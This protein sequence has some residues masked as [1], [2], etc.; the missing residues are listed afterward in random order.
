LKENELKIKSGIKLLEEV[1]GAGQ[2][3]VKGDS[4]SVKLNAWLNSGTQIQTDF[5]ETVKVGS[6]KIISG[7]ENTILGMKI[8][9]K[10]KVKISPHLA[11]GKKGIVGLIPPNSVLIYEIEVLEII[12]NT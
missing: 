3:I 4:V 12:S 9:G 5:K 10:R 2:K 6:R 11:Y 1:D 7:I 8:F